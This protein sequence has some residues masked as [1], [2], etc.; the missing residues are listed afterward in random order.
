MRSRR[1]RSGCGGEINAPR[2]VSPSILGPIPGAPITRPFLLINCIIVTS[3]ATVAA[4]AA[5]LLSV[6]GGGAI[7]SAVAPFV[8]LILLPF[9]AAPLLLSIAPTFLLHRG[10]GA[11]QLA[12]Q[13]NCEPPL[14][15]VHLA[16]TLEDLRGG[17]RLIALPLATAPPANFAVGEILALRAASHQATIVIAGATRQAEG[18]KKEGPLSGSASTRR[19]NTSQSKVAG[20]LQRQK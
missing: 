9:F 17:K 20:W 1:S 18:Q 5:T 12:A 14:L 6:P 8:G 7:L 13:P 4:P 2:P 3:W 19:S 16:S 11:G 10:V 15:Q